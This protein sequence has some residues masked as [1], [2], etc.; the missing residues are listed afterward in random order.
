MSTRAQTLAATFADTNHEVISTVEGIPDDRWGEPCADPDEK[1]S[2]GVVA[3]HIAD[4]YES[5]FGIARL[6]SAGQP[7]PSVSWNMI[8][9]MNAQ[10]AAASSGAT[11]EETLTL[12]RERGDAVKSGIASLSDEQ[13]DMTLVLP[14]FGP[15]EMTVEQLINAL[16]IGHSSTHLPTI[17]GQ[18]S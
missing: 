1:R 8:H 14:L 17:K 3:N 4:S 6:A 16:V 11:R 12:L 10:H 13:L 18:V 2:V 7:M 15:D 9:D 5:T